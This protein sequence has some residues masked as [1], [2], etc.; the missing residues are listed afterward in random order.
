[1]VWAKSSRVP[2][3]HTYTKAVYICIKLGKGQGNRDIGMR[4]WGLGTWGPETRDLGTSSMGPGDVWD[5]D[6]GSQIQGCGN[7]NDYCKSRR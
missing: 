4:V 3:A 7:V 5:R 6:T 2:A 1:M